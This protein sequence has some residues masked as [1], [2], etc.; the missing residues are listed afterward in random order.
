MSRF[1]DQSISSSEP[2]ADAAVLLSDEQDAEADVVVPLPTAGSSASATT[3]VSLR[4]E[5]TNDFLLNT[6]SFRVV[7]EPFIQAV[8]REQCAQGTGDLTSSKASAQQKC[9]KKVAAEYQKV[10]ASMRL[11]YSRTT[12]DA[13]LVLWG[14]DQSANKVV[15]HDLPAVVTTTPNP[16]VFTNRGE[17]RGSR[18][19]QS[20]PN[21]T[22]TM[23][24]KAPYRFVV[25]GLETFD[26]EIEQM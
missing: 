2:A 3:S 17:D 4:D 7:S 19:K 18:A 6:A 1:N 8:V 12:V 14:I 5:V 23:I 20:S 22:I 26:F 10:I 15:W 16:M 25:S 21:K 24:Y 9:A 13:R 11:E